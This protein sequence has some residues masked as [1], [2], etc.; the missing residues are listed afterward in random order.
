MSTTIQ[1]KVFI[2]YSWTSEEYIKRVFNLVNSLIKSGVEVVFDQYDLEEGA[3]LNSYMERAVRDESITK[4]L[5]LCDARYREKADGRNGGVGTEALIMSQEVYNQLNPSGTNQRYIP[6]VMEKDNDG[7]ACLPIY[8]ASRKYIDLSPG[9]LGGFEQLLRYLHGAPLR[10]RPELGTPPTFATASQSAPGTALAHLAALQAIREQRVNVQMLCEEYF[11][12]LYADLNNCRLK[13]YDGDLIFEYIEKFT[14]LR[15]EFVDIIVSLARSNQAGSMIPSIKRM[16]ET[17]F[18]FTQPTAHQTSYTKAEF[19]HFKY[20]TNECFLYTMAAILRYEQFS[21]VKSF[22]DDFYLK[23][24]TRGKELRTYINFYFQL[25][26]LKSIN[27]SRGLGKADLH[28]EILYR[29]ATRQDIQFDHVMQADF[30]LWL[31][32]CLH[33]IV[34]MGF[35]WYPRTLR[36][37]DFMPGPFE[38]FARATSVKYFESFKKA[39]NVLSVSEIRALKGGL[40]QNQDIWPRFDFDWPNPILLAN[41]ENM[42]TKS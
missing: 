19:D 35:R 2:S 32:S 25:E 40:S 24:W 23:I 16:F 15:N 39:L 13:E 41:L 36:Y 20:F 31:Y 18:E 7:K 38:V 17:L 5:I 10:Q 29:T 21:C 3:D 4:V 34:I 8:L 26:S 27:N 42:A 6:V 37:L 33:N 14:T 22:L 30:F 28:C 12:A 1:P 11:D 9:A